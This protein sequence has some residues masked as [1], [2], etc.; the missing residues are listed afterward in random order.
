LLYYL[1]LQLGFW[2][3]ATAQAIALFPSFLSFEVYLIAFSANTFVVLPYMVICDRLQRLVEQPRVRSSSE[4]NTVALGQLAGRVALW[5]MFAIP[6]AS[7][8]LITFFFVI[9]DPNVRLYS[10]LPAAI[11]RG[12]Y[13]GDA[14]TS[15]VRYLR[16]EIGLKRGSTFRSVAATYMGNN[17]PMERTFGKQHRY[18]KVSNSPMFLSG[19]TQN[20]HQ[21]TGLWGFGVPTYDEYAHMITRGLYNFTKEMLTVT[22]RRSST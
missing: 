8:L 11:I 21:K 7:A 20:A 22:K 12:V 1:L 17:L 15:I 13:K 10:S 6:L 2:F 16:Q 5:G 19:L 9:R 4:L 14:E 18:Y 3:F